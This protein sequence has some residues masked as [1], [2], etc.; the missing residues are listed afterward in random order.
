MIQKSWT[1]LQTA[2]QGAG[3]RIGPA[4]DVTLSLLITPD[5]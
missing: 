4:S 3:P 2:A 5:T 1:V